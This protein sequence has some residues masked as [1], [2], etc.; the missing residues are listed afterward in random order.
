MISSDYMNV[1]CDGMVYRLKRYQLNNPHR[2]REVYVKL[3]EWVNHQTPCDVRLSG[4]GCRDS[5]GMMYADYIYINENLPELVT[6]AA[7]SF[8]EI[9]RA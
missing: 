7:L 4:I 2:N 3:S 9:F 6:M 1:H 8:P 5:K